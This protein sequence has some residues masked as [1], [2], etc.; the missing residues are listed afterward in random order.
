MKIIIIILTVMTIL[1]S[2]INVKKTFRNEVNEFFDTSFDQTQMITPEMTASLPVPLQKYLENCGFVGSEMPLNAEVVWKSSSISM[3]PDMKKPMKLKTVQFN[4]VKKP[5]RS[6]YMKAHIAG[7]IPF[8]GRDIYYDGNGHMLGKIAGLFRVFDEKQR[9]IAQ[10]A[11][12]TILAEV[13]MVPGY[14]FQEYMSWEEVSATCVLGRIIIDGFNVS[15]RFYFNE[16]GEYIRFE[17]EDRFYMSPDKGNINM[18]FMVEV[19]DYRQQNNIK[20]PNRVAAS[21]LLPE[22]KFQYWKGE[23]Q[24]MRFN[25]V[26]GFKKIQN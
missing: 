2:C 22:G 7:I 4:S 20:I 14:I 11:L 3:K 9:E 6:A 24:E 26:P 17:S 18:P 23:I 8:D 10:S 21:W 15:G 16:A 1:P 5:F 13:P 19:F 12:I 25:I